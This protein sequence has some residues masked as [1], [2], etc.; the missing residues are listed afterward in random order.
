MKLLGPAAATVAL[1]LLSTAALAQSVAERGPTYALD[2]S[3]DIPVL[4]LAGAAAVTPSLQ[5]EAPPAWCAPLCD[6][7]RVNA[8]DRPAAGVYRPTWARVTDVTVATLV[9]TPIV[10]MA[11][12]E[13]FANT[14]NDL[15]VIAETQLVASAFASLTSAAVRRPRP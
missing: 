5:L 14:L 1:S 12:D 4:A 6:A 7:R 8:F 9:V 10:V 13:G 3:R 15:V 2:L 11:A